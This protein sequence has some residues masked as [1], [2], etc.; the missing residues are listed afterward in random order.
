MLYSTTATSHVLGKLLER[1]STTQLPLRFCQYL[2][3]FVRC[4]APSRFFFSLHNHFD[5]LSNAL[6][7][8][9]SFMTDVSLAR[10][11][12]QHRVGTAVAAI[13]RAT[14]ISAGEGCDIFLALWDLSDEDGEGFSG[15]IRNSAAFRVFCTQLAGLVHQLDEDLASIR[16]LQHVLTAFSLVHTSDSPPDIHPSFSATLIKRVHTLIRFRAVGMQGYNH[17]Q[18]TVEAL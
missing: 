14:D 3:T 6:T 5:T 9:D 15:S 18:H 16:A 4:Q 10:Q 1:Q 2:R 13:A 17:D 12:L 8:L 7:S 11:R